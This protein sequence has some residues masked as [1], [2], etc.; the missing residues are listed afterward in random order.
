[1]IKHCSTCYLRRRAQDQQLYCALTKL[2][3]LNPNEESCSHHQD[4]VLNCQICGKPVMRSTDLELIQ[5]KN[6]T[7][8]K[9][10][11]VC[12]NCGELVWRCSG[13]SHVS[14]CEFET[15]SDPTPK[16]I[17][18]QIR[19]GNQIIV[20]GV[21]NPERIEKFCKNC[22]CFCKDENDCA[23]NFN[24][25]PNFESVLERD[26]QQE[27]EDVQQEPSESTCVHLTKSP[28]SI[29]FRE[30]PLAFLISTMA[31]ALAV[32]AFGKTINIRA[33]ISMP[34]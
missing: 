23:K 16:V 28:Q 29:A 25:C 10:I 33:T 6:E 31:C 17:Q 12:H 14:T 3:I 22:K 20:S 30:N 11:S 2:P 21:K 26:L 15:N 32:N 24:W 7:V 1:M 9:W 18:K 8:E 27:S 19:Q 34:T 13:C 4:S 5:L